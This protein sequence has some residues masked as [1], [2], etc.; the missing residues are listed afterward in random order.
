ML[1]ALLYISE[2]MQSMSP[3][4]PRIVHTVTTSSEL[5]TS[6]IS[7]GYYE[8]LLEANHEPRVGPPSYVPQGYALQCIN[9]HVYGPNIPEEHAVSF[10]Y[11]KDDQE[12]QSKF[13]PK[14]QKGI[15]TDPMYA[16]WFSEYYDAG[17]IV[18]TRSTEYI[19]E[20]DP[21]Y[22]DKIK[23]FEIERGT[24]DPQNECP[25][26]E[27]AR[28]ECEIKAEYP[29]VPLANG[30]PTVPTFVQQ[31]GTRVDGMV[32]YMDH[33][34]LVYVIGGQDPDELFKIAESIPQSDRTTTLTN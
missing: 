32:M 26:H 13:L 22:N 23:H 4:K 15:E 27:F 16:D 12:F 8:S 10:Y 17:G 33:N 31:H 5:N 7:I 24:G 29:P 34:W 20:D 25:L 6:C 9:L 2:T 30:N 18:I 21:R 14:I 3:N 19:E 1:F 28:G 11:F